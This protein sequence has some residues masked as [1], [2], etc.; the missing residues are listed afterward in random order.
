MSTTWINIEVK[1][2][3][4]KS[5]AGCVIS[6]CRIAACVLLKILGNSAAA[7]SALIIITLISICAVPVAKQGDVKTFCLSLDV[8]FHIWMK[9]SWRAGRIAQSEASCVFPL[10]F[11]IS[12]M[13]KNN[14]KNTDAHSVVCQISA[15]HPHKV[16]FVSPVTERKTF[17]I[18]RSS[19]TLRI[20]IDRVVAVM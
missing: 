15:F 4:E 3:K 6:F 14:K 1:K 11:L 9:H 19:C 13:K 5:Y 2:K 7:T 12:Y 20:T 17:L 18:R 16:V 10:Q 8:T